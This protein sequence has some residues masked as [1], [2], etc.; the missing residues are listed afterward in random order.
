MLIFRHFD[1]QIFSNEI[2]IVH[3]EMHKNNFM[4]IEKNLQQITNIL[5]LNGTLTECPG[6]VH[7]KMGIAIFFFHYAQHTGNEL[8]AD[9]AMDLIGEVLT[10]IH[11]NSPADYEIGLAG[12]GVGIDYLIQNNFLNIEED[13]CGD[14]DYRMYRAVMYD[15]WQDFSQ[16]NGLIGYGYY[17]IT[18]LR[19]QVPSIKAR[20]CLLRITVLIEENLPEISIKEQT[21]VYCFLHD[22]QEMPGFEICI[23]LLK[24]FWNLYLQSSDVTRSFPRLGD[25]AVGNIVRAYQRNRYFNDVLQDEIDIALK[26]IYDLDM[27]K[28][29]VGTGLLTGYAGEG[30]LRLTVLDSTNVSWSHLL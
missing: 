15:P 2:N 23:G 12:I 22:L 17:W 5:V 8:F 26:Q 21:D 7:G 18:R 14:F 27:E 30:M 13:I 28:P 9:Y 10:Q 25:S 11:V 29:P 20:E 19:Y 16:Y 1:K 4:I 3:K 24:Q 6:L